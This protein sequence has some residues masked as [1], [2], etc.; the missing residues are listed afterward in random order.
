LP[1]GAFRFLQGGLLDFHVCSLNSY[2]GFTTL[3]SGNKKA[4]TGKASLSGWLRSTG[5]FALSV[6]YCQAL[7]RSQSCYRA[8][9]GFQ[10]CEG[11]SAPSY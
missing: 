2:I 1:V 3:L 11:R 5:A 9:H 8:R 10:W 7:M 6:Y 4:P